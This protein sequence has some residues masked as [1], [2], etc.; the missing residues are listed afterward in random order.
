MGGTGLWNMGGG[1]LLDG[2]TETGLPGGGICGTIGW[3]TGEP[4]MGGLAVLY[5]G[6]KSPGGGG[7]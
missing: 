3:W 7:P 5:R 4:A 6:S 1:G 2:A